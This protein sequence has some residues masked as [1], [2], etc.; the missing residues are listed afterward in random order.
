MIATARH[1]KITGEKKPLD[2]F[3]YDMGNKLYA[4]YV[5]AAF[6]KEF[7]RDTFNNENPKEEKEGDAIELVLGLFELWDSVPRCIPNKLQGQKLVNEM[8]RGIECSLIDFCSMEGARLS[9]TNRKLTK[10]RKTR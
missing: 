1:I 10:R 9:P 7:L 5:H 8:R 6:S 3:A 4:A 2:R